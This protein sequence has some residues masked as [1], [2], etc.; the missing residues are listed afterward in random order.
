MPSRRSRPAVHMVG[1]LR[2][3]MRITP[4]TTPGWTGPRHKRNVSR[5]DATHAKQ[6]GTR[7]R[8]VSRR[9]CGGEDGLK[10]VRAPS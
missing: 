8:D 7:R 1:H 10:Q 2:G 9:I 6:Q 3:S 5:R 4:S